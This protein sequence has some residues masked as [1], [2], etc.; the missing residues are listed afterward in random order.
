MKVNQRPTSDPGTASGDPVPEPSGAS[1]P[2]TPPPPPP[3]AAEPATSGASAQP[4]SAPVPSVPGAPQTTAYRHSHGAGATAGV[5]LIVIGAL[6]LVGRFLPG[7]DWWDLWPLVIIVA[8]LVQSLTPGHAGWGANRFF[9]GLVTVAFGLVALGVTTDYLGFDVVWRI[10]GLWP[11]FVIALGFDLLGKA[12][13]SNWVRV[14]GSIAI[15]AVLA[16]ASAITIADSAGAGAGGLSGRPSSSQFSEPLGAIT[17]GR[18]S[19]DVGVASVRLASGADLV[20][21]SGTSFVGDPTVSVVR[22]NDHATVGIDSGKTGGMMFVPGSFQA[23][24]DVAI[25]R[26]VAWDLDIS[27]GVSQLEADLSDLRVSSLEFKPGMADCDLRLGA[28]LM[29][30]GGSKCSIRSGLSAVKISV[31]RGAAVR[32]ESESGLTDHDLEDVFVSQ[33]RGVWETR[34]YAQA[35]SDGRPTWLIELKS[36]LGSIEIDTY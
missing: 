4:L 8:G 20:R 30:S 6:L 5:V 16:Y 17:R 27:T 10:L 28:P 1:Q 7:Q 2:A 25:A 31:P 18:M 3:P 33:G 21:V 11:V 29:G 36:G 22:A 14:L 12:L 15:I 34:G 32:I 24:M 23:R 9:D 19:L 26:D 13:H 35:R